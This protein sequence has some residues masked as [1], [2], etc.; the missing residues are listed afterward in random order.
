MA[1]HQSLQFFRQSRR[2]RSAGVA[3]QLVEPFRRLLQTWLEADDTVQAQQ[4][5]DA[6]LQRDPLAHQPLAFPLRPPHVL[7]GL[8]RDAHHRADPRFAAQPGQQRTQQH[9][10]VD[11]ISLRSPPTA[12]HRNARRMHDLHLEAMRQQ[13]PRDP[14]P[15]PAC[16][17]GQHRS[18]HAAA[19]PQRLRLPAFDLL[20]QPD[21]IAR[22]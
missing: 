21:H 22:R 15:I 18:L 17:V 5:L 20:Q 19:R 3:A 1:G 14:E 9:V 6:V 4:V 13:I 7:L 10:E 11:P 12:F 8:A 16:L 2:Q